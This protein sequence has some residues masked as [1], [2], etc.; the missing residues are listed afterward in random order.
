MTIRAGNVSAIQAIRDAWVAPPRPLPTDLAAR[1]S[2]L[3]SIFTGASMRTRFEP[4]CR[5]PRAEPRRSR[6]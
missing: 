6:S 1:A 3:E 4:S 5:P 2:E